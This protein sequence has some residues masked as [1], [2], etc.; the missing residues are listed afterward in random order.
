MSFPETATCPCCGDRLR[1][2]R[3]RTPVL[4]R[5]V[6]KYHCYRWVGVLNLWQDPERTWTAQDIVWSTTVDC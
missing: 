1:G 3:M 4:K 2:I 5:H 6:V